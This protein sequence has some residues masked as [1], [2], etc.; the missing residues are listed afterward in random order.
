[1]RYLLIPAYDD[2]QLGELVLALP[3]DDFH[4]L[5]DSDDIAGVLSAVLPSTTS[6]DEQL[7]LAINQELA[8]ATALECA[9]R[10]RDKWGD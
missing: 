2:Q 1:M 7:V 3:T 8:H 5:S 6:V 9:V 4:V 10:A